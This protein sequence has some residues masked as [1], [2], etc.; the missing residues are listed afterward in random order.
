MKKEHSSS[1]IIATWTFNLDEGAFI[2]YHGDD[3]GGDHRQGHCESSIKKVIASFSRISAVKGKSFS[4]LSALSGDDQDAFLQSTGLFL[5]TSPVVIS[6]VTRL[7]DEKPEGY[8]AEPNRNKLIELLSS[9]ESGPT[10]NIIHALKAP[11]NRIKGIAAIMRDELNGR[12]ELEQL[13]EY[14]S[15]SADRLSHLAEHLLSVEPYP[16]EQ[17]VAAKQVVLS[18]AKSALNFVDFK[19]HTR[20]TSRALLKSEHADALESLLINLLTHES[21]ALSGRNEI[22][23]V[24]SY[25]GLVCIKLNQEL[26][27][28]VALSATGNDLDSDTPPAGSL[29]LLSTIEDALVVRTFQHDKITYKIYLPQVSIE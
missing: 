7:I 6:G 12:D 19:V 22:E 20:A 13:M 14:L 28:N 25:E 9:Y 5:S 24:D 29:E 10:R 27:M 4:V 3:S 26:A 8:T 11:V 23:L 21:N 16:N 2:F 17:L 15:T 1:S 18:S